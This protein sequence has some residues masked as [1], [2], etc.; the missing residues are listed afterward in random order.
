MTLTSTST[1]YR[2]ALT[3]RQSV[4]DVAVDPEAPIRD[5]E[6]SVRGLGAGRVINAARC[7]A[8]VR[9]PIPA[10][11][12]HAHGSPFTPL[13]VLLIKSPSSFFNCSAF[14]DPTAS[15]IAW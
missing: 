8:S 4:A 14:F 10:S 6:S 5:R 3:L 13:H 7:C 15:S 12:A 2:R 9:Q 11:V 1:Q